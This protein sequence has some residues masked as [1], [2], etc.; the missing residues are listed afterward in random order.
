[1]SRDALPYLRRHTL[2]G[3]AGMPALQQALSNIEQKKGL[4]PHHKA[5]K[6]DFTCT[7]ELYFVSTTVKGPKY[8]YIAGG[9]SLS[10]K[11]SLGS[12]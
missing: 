11:R 12:R 5:S 10:P 4:L 7:T 6:E 1:M 8:P 2:H 9:S 3:E